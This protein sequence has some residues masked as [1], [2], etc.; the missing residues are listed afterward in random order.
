MNLRV[1]LAAAVLGALAVT[2]C[3][4]KTS[5][6]T[7]SG[8]SVLIAPTVTSVSP[9]EGA[10]L[11]GTP[12]TISGANFAAGATVTVGGVAATSVTVASSTTITAVTGAHAAGPGD[13]V[14]TQGGLSGTLPSGFTFIT[15][16]PPTV[17]SI[18]PRAGSSAGGTPIT[19]TGTNFAPGA[20]VTIGGAAATSV[21][22]SSLTSLTAVTG[23]RST[24]GAADVVV[25]KPGY[26]IIAECLANGA[27]MLYTSRGRFA[28]YDVLVAGLPR[29][30]RSRFIG[31]EDLFGGRWQAHLDAVLA[32]P[33][34]PDHPRTDGAALA[35][36]YLLS[37]TC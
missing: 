21:V 32:Q 24:T 29:I 22:V 16:P 7:P 17:T 35:S 27:A 6:T 15:L 34:P 14:V 10:T 19:I 23:A 18:F 5:S 31:H 37:L 2:A 11:G 9:K 1:L 28:E 36:R 30:L 26:G 8:P 20:S 25:T 33:A 12:I 4:D 13:V 3:G